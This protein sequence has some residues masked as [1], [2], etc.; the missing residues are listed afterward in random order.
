MKRVC[1]DLSDLGGDSQYDAMSFVETQ[2]PD[3][4]ECSPCAD[5]DADYSPEECE[6]TDNVASSV[7]PMVLRPTPQ[8]LSRE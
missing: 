6:D 7:P 4:S 8:R 2:P 1:A 3:D 5:N